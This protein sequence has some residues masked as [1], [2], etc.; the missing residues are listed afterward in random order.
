M[1]AAERHT[2]QYYLKKIRLRRAIFALQ[3]PIKA[4]ASSKIFAPAASNFALQIPINGSPNNEIF[5]PAAS[6][7]RR[8]RK[9]WYLY[10]IKYDFTF[11]NTLL[12]PAAGGKFCDFL[13]CL[14]DFL[15][16]LEA[17]ICLQ[18]SPVRPP[19]RDPNLPDRTP[20]RN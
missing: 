9:L 17:K 1:T 19:A 15:T 3:I 4:P 13:V 14:A 12:G 2:S 20:A 16:V 7:E 6:I 18:R 5:A 10:S 11:K 8:R